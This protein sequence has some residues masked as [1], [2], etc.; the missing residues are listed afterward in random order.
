MMPPAM[1]TIN[2]FFDLNVFMEMPT[3]KESFQMKA[4]MKITWH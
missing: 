1:Q 3:T 4:H 2:D